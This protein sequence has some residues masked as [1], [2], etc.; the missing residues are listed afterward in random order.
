MAIFNLTADQTFWAAI[1]GFDG[2]R[3]N[4]TAM[5][6]PSTIA[7]ADW[8]VGMAELFELLT[9]DSSPTGVYTF[10]APTGLALRRRTA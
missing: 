9:S 4:G 7:A 8:G 5:V 10:T 3:W 6:A 1:C 2:T